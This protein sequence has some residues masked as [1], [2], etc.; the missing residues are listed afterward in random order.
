MMVR[1]VPISAFNQKEYNTKMTVDY[2]YE[3]H[4]CYALYL[5]FMF[6]L[7]QM[8]TGFAF[9]GCFNFR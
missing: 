6:L 1:K 2:D 8:K 4:T 3:F 5:F 9:A 7:K